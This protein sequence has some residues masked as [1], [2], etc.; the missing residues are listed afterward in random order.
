M[1]RFAVLLLLFCCVTS[2]SG[3]AAHRALRRGDKAYQDQN[4]EEAQ[5]NYDEALRE[6]NSAKGNYNAGNSLYQR[7]DYE[8]AWVAAKLDALMETLGEVLDTALEAGEPTNRVA[9]R[10]ARARIGRD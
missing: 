8:E 5:R 2:L 6:E 1:L 3:Q 10:I 9:D 7:G 4:Y